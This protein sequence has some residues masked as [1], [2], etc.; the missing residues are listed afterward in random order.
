VKNWYSGGARKVTKNRYTLRRYLRFQLEQMSALNQQHQFEELSFELARQRICR[1]ILPATGP[2]Q[3]GGDQGR[4]AETF[5]SYLAS[6]DIAT[7]SRIGLAEDR[8]LVIACTLDKKLPTKIKNDLA[9]I[10]ASG[11]VPAAVYYFATPD[12]PVAKRHELQAFSKRKYGFDLEI[13]DGQAIADQLSDPDTFWIAEQFLS[14]PADMFPEIEGDAEYQTLRVRWLGSDRQISDFTDFLEV[15]RGLRRATFEKPLQVDL[16]RWMDL[17]Q[18]IIDAVP[19][20]FA[21]KALYEIAVAQLRGRKTLDPARW[22]VERFFSRIEGELDADDVQDIVLLASYATTAHYSGDFSGG[23]ELVQKWRGQ[24][25]QALS[26][27]LASDLP[28]AERYQLLLVAR[29]VAPD[30]FSKDPELFSEMALPPWEEAVEIAERSPFA[31]IDTLNNLMQIYLP[32]I[33]GLPRYQRL[34]DR[35]DAVVVKRSGK[36]AGAE[37]GRQRAMIHAQHGQFVPAIDQLQRAKEGWFH[38]ATMYGS[39]LAMLQLSEFYS[40]LWLPLAARYYASAAFKYAFQAKDEELRPLIGRAALE[41]SATYL[42]AGEGISFLHSV[43]RAAQIHIAHTSDGENMERHGALAER[44]AEAAKV[45]ALLRHILPDQTQAI[46]A[47]VE[48]WPID[49]GY[50]RSVRALADKPPW[51]SMSRPEIE[52]RLA[53]DIGQGLTYDLGPELCYRWNALG[54]A[55]TIRAVSTAHAIAE[56]IGAAFQ[57]AIADLG[58]EDLAILPSIIDIEITTSGDLKPKLEPLSDNAQMRYRLTMP[59]SATLGDE[60]SFTLM[61]LSEILGNASALPTED[62]L[63]VIK[64]KLDRGLLGKAFWVRPVSRLFRD[65][66]ELLV[67]ENLD[68]SDITVP[69]DAPRPKPLGS[70]DLAWRSGD[71]PT[72]TTARAYEALSNRYRRLTPAVLANLEALQADPAAMSLLSE[73]HDEGMLDWQIYGV[74]FNFMMQDAIEAKAGAGAI[75]K[76]SPDVMRKLLREFEAGKSPSI[77]LANFTRDSLEMVRWSGLFAALP[78]WELSTHRHTPDMEATRRFLAVRYHHFEDDIDH[79]DLFGW[80]PVSGRRILSR[81]ETSNDEA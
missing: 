53:E 8:P 63:T 48:S 2:V 58:D 60:A 5:R 27:A 34:A 64:R 28:D 69:D 71:G 49:P 74:I 47:A 14:V 37:Q 9:T 1:T 10:S 59:A 24:A 56:W 20:P 77:N 25:D 76:D 40:R 36:T 30:R 33:G 73:M 78:S 70:E 79:P 38:E 55:W 26:D 13:L 72:Y 29:Q 3:A 67:G 65:I 68:L 39:I 42:T 66:R 45:R 43:G 54:V 21:R 18:A 31:D 80:S 6:S 35:I 41:I 16:G 61:L 17:I 22:A 15:K 81:P 12:L 7:S 50:G 44:L 23:L 19:I 11:T 52:Q 4:D 62:F 51:K 32:L 75:L 57:I 46:D